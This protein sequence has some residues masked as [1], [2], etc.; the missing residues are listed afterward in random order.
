[1][2]LDKD[3][4]VTAFEERSLDLQQYYSKENYLS[5]CSKVTG[6][7]DVSGIDY[8]PSNS[9]WL[10]NRSLYNIKAALLP[11]GNT[12]PSNLVAH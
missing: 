4:R 7:F 12:L 8:E 10:I 6:L 2:Q 5:F 9:M 11:A 1:M 3:A